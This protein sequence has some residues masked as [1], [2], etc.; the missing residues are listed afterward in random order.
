MTVEKSEARS[1]VAGYFADPALAI[2]DGRY[3]LYPTS[4]G[5]EDW[6]G[7]EFRVFSSSDLADW[8]DHGVIL[9][10]A[11]DV[12]WASEHAWAPAIATRNGKYYFYFTAEN[13]IGVA[14]ADGPTGPFRDLGHPLVR[15]GQYSGLTIDPSV[16]IDAD[17]TPYL[18]WGNTD[19]HL[20]RLGDDMVSFDPDEVATFNPTE[21]REAAWIH[22]RNGV[23]YLSWSVDDTRDPDYH[24]RYATGPGPFGPWTDRG[25]L[26]R[27]VPERG[28]LGTGHHSIVQLPGT[29]DWIIAYHRFAIP[30]G[31]GVRRELV[32]DRLVH[33]AD[34]SLERVIPSYEPVRIPLDR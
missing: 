20:V 10:L 19:A 32:F 12:P 4:D 34:G 9:S 7:S 14:V 3:Y 30:G 5:F 22:V 2:F 23:Y 28:I 29:D 25:I 16:F 15:D 21:F 6:G 1:R 8:T 27:Q 31:S 24:L 26:L 33:N 17:G 13:N 11:D 18:I